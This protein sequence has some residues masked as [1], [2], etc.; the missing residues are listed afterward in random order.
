[1]PT[2]RTMV[3]LSAGFAL[4]LLIVWNT[5]TLSFSAVLPETVLIFRN[6]LS[7]A[8][9]IR[10]KA[11]IDVGAAAAA[12]THAL[13]AVVASPIARDGLGLFV[14]TLADQGKVRA[15]RKAARALV[16]NGNRDDVG[17]LMRLRFAAEDGNVPLML[18][19]SDA[20]L[21]STMQEN[22]DIVA[23]LGAEAQDPAFANK[24]AAKLAGSP[25]WR[26]RFL[27]QL[28]AR[29]ELAGGA[30]NVLSALAKSKA[31]PTPDEMTPYFW[32]TARTLDPG[33]A[34]SQWNMFFGKRSNAYKNAVNDPEFDGKS[35]VPPFA[36][37]LPRDEN[38][39]TSLVSDG[40][41]GSQLFA[42]Y[43]GVR[44]SLL[45]TQSTQ[46]LPGYWRLKF[47]A[48]SSESES[49][50]KI[51][52]TLACNP[53]S[54]QIMQHTVALLP[55]MQSYGQ[56]VTIP[57]Q[58]CANQRLDFFAEANFAQEG[59]QISLD[60]VRLTLVNVGLQAAP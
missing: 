49:R 23:G 39:A 15:A 12:Q 38:I 11:F 22:V 10:A 42:E 19:R 29:P 60:D 35:G 30:W 51:T 3:V 5:L 56:L 7:V 26:Y 25:P 36:W 57:D 40:A 8:H 14:M 54:I 34:R 31:P 20:V 53:S 43:S 47:H 45:V 59:V 16:I 21:R 17:N 52:V 4:G 27:H 33:I 37:Y 9:A 13:A 2:S 24:L 55:A 6:S 41:H 44:T 28:G 18:Q 50:Q 1:M 48:A 32:I 58:G 46:F